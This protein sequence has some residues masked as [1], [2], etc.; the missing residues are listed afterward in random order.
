MMKPLEHFKTDNI[1]EVAQLQF[2]H[3]ANK[4]LRKLYVLN[5]IQMKNAIKKQEDMQAAERDYLRNRDY[6]E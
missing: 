6:G 3:F 1:P 2:E 4:R 5:N